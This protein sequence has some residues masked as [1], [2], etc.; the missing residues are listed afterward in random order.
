MD[1]KRLHPCCRGLERDIQT[2]EARV[3][4]EGDSFLTVALPALGKAFDQGL[5]IGRMP[6]VPGFSSGTRAIPRFLGG[7]LSHVFDA[8]TGALLDEP[9]IEYILSIRQVLLFFKKYLPA[10]DRREILHQKAIKSFKSDDESIRALSGSRIETL[11]HA[12]RLVLQNLDDFQ[13]LVCRHGPGAVAEGCSANQ[14]W[15]VLHQGLS[16][17]DPN[18]MDSGYDLFAFGQG[19]HLP[20]HK[21]PA[22]TPSPNARLVTVPKT[23][24]ALRTITVEPCLNQFVQQGLNELLRDSIEKCPIMRRS[25]SLR[26]QVPNQKLALLGSISGD[27]CTMDLSAASDMLSLQTVEAVFASKPRFLG[28]MLRTRTPIVNV[29]DVSIEMKK[30]AGM[31]NA[32]TFPV[33]SVTFALI[34]MC[35]ALEG[36]VLSIRQL[37]RAA[38]Q[39]RVF[40]DD[41]IVRRDIFSKVADWMTSFGLKINHSKT[42]SVGNFRE[43]CGVDAFKGVDV[44]PC[45][46]RYHP[47]LTAKEPSA[48][49]GIVSTSNQLWLRCYY[50]T[51][52][53]LR[54]HVER[55]HVL[56]LVSFNSSGLGWYTRRNWATIQRWN[57]NLHRF[58]SRTY[59]PTPLRRKDSL[60]GVPALLKAFHS[61]RMSEYDIQQVDE[62]HLE[63]SVRRF[64]LKLRKRWEQS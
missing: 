3:K 42:F 63:S 21:V 15:S 40:G 39:I 1:M 53:F 13:E 26:T 50:N 55:T 31:G 57:R 7:M 47:D 51:A 12:G 30:Y 5:A 16:E 33:Q 64:N 27:W 6:K 54:K 38:S 11:S 4:D 35:A 28:L 9:S 36:S 25:L 24:T 43:S 61:P 23:C 22:S 34:A 18:L 44:T 48:F 62:K 8:S 58:E 19:Y 37:R 32:T 59:V 10:D 52:E 49:A 56:P 60:S 17:L 41:I 2:L 20:D 29:D 45:Y 46:L 14:K